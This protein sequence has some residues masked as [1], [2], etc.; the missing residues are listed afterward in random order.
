MLPCGAT[1]GQFRCC[2]LMRRRIVV[3]G[4]SKSRGELTEVPCRDD[5]RDA[6]HKTR[7][8]SGGAAIA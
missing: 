5:L 1:R 7:A 4:T 3:A 6:A 2:V 8:Y